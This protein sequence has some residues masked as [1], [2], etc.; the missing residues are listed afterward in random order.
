MLTLRELKNM[1]ETAPSGQKT[2][3]VRELRLSGKLIAERKIG[4]SAGIAAYR[5]GYT[6]YYAGR[7]AT[8]FRIHACSGYCYDSC[9]RMF[10]GRHGTCALCLRVRTACSAT[11]LPGN[12]TGAYRTAP[13]QRNGA[14]CTLRNPVQ[15]VHWTALSGRKLWKTFYPC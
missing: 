6:V 15:K 13:N 1:A 9:S 3:T 4:E 14:D 7:G 8:V 12:R 5:N 11:L 2:P 10:D